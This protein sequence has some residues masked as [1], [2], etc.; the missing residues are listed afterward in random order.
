MLRW[1]RSQAVAQLSYVLSQSANKWFR[2]VSTNKYSFPPFS[3]T[4]NQ[5]IIRTITKER[6]YLG[7]KGRWQVCFYFVY[8]NEYRKPNGK[9]S[10][11]H[12]KPQ[13]GIQI[14]SQ[15]LRIV[16]VCIHAHA[17]DCVYEK[18][19]VSCQNICLMLIVHYRFF[20]V[21]WHIIS[22]LKLNFFWR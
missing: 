5:K 8:I 11:I 21:W 14:Y 19:R 16:S 7:S 17:C 13:V 20:S 4:F 18:Q 6:R 2:F 10:E 9:L 3:G 22:F 12:R 1:N 15:G